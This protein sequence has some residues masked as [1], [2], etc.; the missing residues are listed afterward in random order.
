MSEESGNRGFR[1]QTRGPAKD[2]SG[3]TSTDDDLVGD[4]A[5]EP[6]APS[7]VGDGGTKRLVVEEDTRIL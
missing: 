2:G 1:C 6:I 5:H 7:G 4:Q 3:E